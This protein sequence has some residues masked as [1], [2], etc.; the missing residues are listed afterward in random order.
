MVYFKTALVDPILVDVGQLKLVRDFRQRV[1]DAGGLTWD[2]AATADF[3]NFVRIHLTKFIQD[4]RDRHKGAEQLE[5]GQRSTEMLSA[6]VSETHAGL[7]D[8]RDN[9]GF[10]DLVEESASALQR[11]AE[12]TARLTSATTTLTDQVNAHGAKLISSNASKD[13]QAVK[14]IFSEFA[15]DLNTYARV[16]REET[17]V[18]ASSVE[19]GIRGAG[20]AA[21]IAPE[22][23]ARQ[24]VEPVL[25]ELADKLGLLR[26]AYTSHLERLEETRQVAAGL[27]RFTVAFNRARRNAN[28][29]M[30]A[31]EARLRS[32][33][34]L[35]EEAEASIRGMYEGETS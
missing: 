23:G 7:S 24:E 31:F 2:F 30:E 27:P 14:R 21:G 11:S 12:S 8:D 6:A 20:Q 32:A 19:D 13:V 22:F 35:L 1:R 29:A 33:A 10:F 26:A 18:F 25:A 16:V 5:E 15:H 3:E 4:W 34:R 17:P 9:V 28:D